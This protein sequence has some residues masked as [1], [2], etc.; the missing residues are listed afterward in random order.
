MSRPRLY[1]IY[2]PDGDTA[3]ALGRPG[4]DQTEASHRLHALD[5]RK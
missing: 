4:H 2:E 1:L 5:T 3:I